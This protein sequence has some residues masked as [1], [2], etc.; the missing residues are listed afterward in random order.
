[1][2]H[3]SITITAIHW[4]RLTLTVDR[5]GRIRTVTSAYDVALMNFEP[6]VKDALRSAVD[7]LI[8]SRKGEK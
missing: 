1:M 6:A 2:R 5:N 3:I 4:P 8:K 7:E